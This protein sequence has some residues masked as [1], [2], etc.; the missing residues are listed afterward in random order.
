MAAKCRVTRS[1]TNRSGGAGKGGGRRGHVPT[2]LFYLLVTGEGRIGSLDSRA[3]T[4]ARVKEFGAYPRRSLADER[5]ARSGS[6]MAP[7]D[8]T[9]RLL[10]GFGHAL[11]ISAAQA[12]TFDEHIN[13]LLRGVQGRP[14]SFCE[15]ERRESTS[16]ARETHPPVEVG[17]HFGRRSTA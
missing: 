14:P 4:D 12:I 5:R 6:G 2:A 11:T 1:R 9:G 16:S 15:S 3:L 13:A 10:L 17:Q 7:V 8:E